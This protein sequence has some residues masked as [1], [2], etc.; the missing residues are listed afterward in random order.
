MTQ[1]TQDDNNEVAQCFPL[2]VTGKSITLTLGTVSSPAVVAGIY[3]FV[4]GADCTVCRGGAAVASDMQLKAGQTE[5]FSLPAD[6][7]IDTTGTGSLVI[8]RVG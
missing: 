7:L 6:S 5:Y 8:T 2:P 4:A 1:L 3:R